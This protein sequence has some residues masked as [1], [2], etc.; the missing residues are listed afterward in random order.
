MNPGPSIWSAAIN[1]RLKP[2]SHILLEPEVK[3][4]PVMAEFTASHPGSYWLP[5]NGYDWTTYLKLFAPDPPRP[6]WPVDH[7]FPPFDPL[8][9]PPED[10]INTDIIFTGNLSMSDSGG[11]RLLAQ[12]LT[13]CALGQW[14]QKFG[15]VRFLVWT[16]DA[17]RDRYLP[18][19]IGGRN[20]AAV[21]AETVADV[22]V[23]V[24]GQAS[25]AG[26]GHPRAAKTDEEGNPIEPKLGVYKG[27]AARAQ[28]RLE[29]EL[30]KE[31]KKKR[32]PRKITDRPMTVEELE[33]ALV[34][35]EKSGFV[36]AW[37][38]RAA[39]VDPEGSELRYT[40]LN[41]RELERFRGRLLCIKPDSN[42]DEITKLF[43]CFAVTDRVISA[44]RELLTE[45]VMKF[46]DAEGEHRWLLDMDYPSWWYR[47]DPARIQ[48]LID[49]LA[50]GDLRAGLNIKQHFGPINEET[51]RQIEVLEGFET[52][53]EDSDPAALQRR[54]EYD[55]YH[56]NWVPPLDN[57]V[58]TQ[59]RTDEIF[60]IHNGTL[61]WSHRK[62][63]PIVADHM[64]FYPATP[65][66]L[67]DFAPIHLNEYFRPQDPRLR[68]TN[69]EV[70]TWVLRNLFAL[71]AR[72]L[73]TA[74][75]SMVAGGSELLQN[76]DQSAGPIDGNMRPRIMSV[77][78]LVA[79]TK[80]WKDWPFRDLV[81]HLESASTRG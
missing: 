2:R 5:L 73:N 23:V 46:F 34:A 26:K 43:E 44:R 42:E 30:E 21:T 1:E 47:E 54:A 36:R 74:L 35:I 39:K 49:K 45:S 20:R 40:R 60:A 19:G 12:F 78:Q 53:D 6:P 58:L 38:M 59:S 22:Q 48:A 9:V 33:E 71:R 55:K 37:R 41:C 68:E 76:I 81:E 18:R 10:G 56:D 7:S 52:P 61:K 63:D 11:D 15:R 4:K 8:F 65:L 27:R 64:D 80:A 67:L 13:C 17:L 70:Y 62:F 75:M 28:V 50:K 16:Q 25:R 72:S 77:G 32:S 66:A 57:A 3:F 51:Q 24:S 69:W 29:K 14:V 31:L 79:L